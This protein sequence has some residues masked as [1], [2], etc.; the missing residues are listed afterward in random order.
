MK[1][2]DFTAIGIMTGTSMDGVDLSL[3]KSDGYDAF[4]TIFNKFFK[5]DQ[6]LLNNLINLRNKISLD[7]DLENY[8]NELNSLNRD[9][10]FFIAK[11]LNDLILYSNE[12]VDLIGFHGQTIF[13]NS[14]KKISIQIGDGNLLSQLTKKIVISNFRQN[15]LDNGGQGAPLTPIFHKLISKL[16]SIKTEVKYPLNIINIGGI[17]NVTQILFNSKTD[18]LDLFASDIGPGNCLIDQWIKKNSKKFFDANGEIAKSGIVN[19]LIYNQAVENFSNISYNKSLDINDFDISFV[20]GLSLEDGCATVTKFSAHLI[21]DGIKNINNLN[22]NYPVFNLI[23]GGG[24][25]NTTLIKNINDCLNYIDI[26]LV[27]IDNYNFDGDFIESQA[28]GYLAIRTFLNLPI[29]FPTTT[30]CQTPTVGGI[31]NKN[32]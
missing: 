3:I 17:T 25:K 2:K 26:D 28:F 29:S 21:A 14:P 5:F 9:F 8:S 24:R 4:S 30:G 11:V 31:V 23:C 15:D 7:G 10:T 16:I 6:K 22:N 18:D 27:D 20:K 13:H 19:D 12:N 32:F 1:K